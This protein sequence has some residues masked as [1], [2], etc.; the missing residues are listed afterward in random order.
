MFKLNSLIRTGR[1]P[2]PRPMAKGSSLGTQVA[3]L[4]LVA[5]MLTGC[6]SKLNQ[7]LD[8]AK[9]QAAATGQAQQVV[10]VDK[11]GTHGRRQIIDG[12]WRAA[13]TAG[14]GA[15]AGGVDAAGM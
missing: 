15:M 11:N 7:A 14:S 9:K 6:Q 2:S 4:L 10:S 12:I 3:L 13:S 5:V 8:Q 1:M